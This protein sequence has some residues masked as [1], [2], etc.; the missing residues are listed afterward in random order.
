MTPE[1]R[2]S[3]GPAQCRSCGSEYAP[4]AR[5]CPTCGKAI[6]K[7]SKRRSV[8]IFLGV[9]ALAVGVTAAVAATRS[10]PSPA[11]NGESATSDS[12]IT[13]VD[14]A[15]SLR[16][17][18]VTRPLAVLYVRCEERNRLA[19]FSRG[20]LHAARCAKASV[21]RF[22]P[23][24]VPTSPVPCSR[25]RKDAFSRVLRSERRFARRTCR[26]ATR[27]VSVVLVPTKA[28]VAL[29]FATLRAAR[30][31]AIERKRAEAARRAAVIAHRK[32]VAQARAE[33]QALITKVRAS[34]A[35]HTPSGNIRC[36]FFLTNPARSVVC[37]MDSPAANAQL[38]LGYRRIL[39]GPVVTSPP[40]V[41]EELPYGVTWRR[42]PLHCSAD[43]AKGLTCTDASTSMGFVL[44]I[45][46]Q[47]AFGGATWE[48]VDAIPPGPYATPPAVPAVVPS[49]TPPPAPD[50]PVYVD[51][52]YPPDPNGGPY[53]PGGGG[54]PG[55][56]NDG[57]MSGSVGEQGACSHHG[58]V[59]G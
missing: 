36:E 41:G 42:G 55:M 21:F 35:F 18:T 58:G 23:G 29:R 51:P 3:D 28:A 7:A 48:Y 19:V 44:S 59:A 27:S 13:L 34:D 46:K 24:L 53:D 47:Y 9:V 17:Q 11:S 37:V 26:G 12:S 30:N 31:R 54:H 50:P 15:A 20:R 39:Y 14:P 32:A 43:F 1:E 5:F 57:T 16:K 2:I 6:G 22:H 40:R 8:W 33:R 25:L 56:C 52:N 10:N 45:A 38:A 4:G 49:Y